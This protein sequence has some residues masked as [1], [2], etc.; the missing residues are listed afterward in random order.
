M[1][2]DIDI[3]KN[4]PD[5]KP[6]RIFLPLK[7]SKQLYRAQCVYQKSDPPKLSLLFKPGFLPVDDISLSQPCIISIDMG[8]PNVSLEAMIQKVAS[9]QILQMI[10]KKSISHEQMREFFR[11]D[12]T[13]KIISKSFH[14]ELFGNK[15]KAWSVEGSTVDISGSGILALFP[16]KTPA[17][18]Q[19][20]LEISIPSAEPETITVLAHQVRAVK[21]EDNRY[22]I[23]YHFDDISTEDRD[24]IIGCC[25][26]IQRK[27]L[28]LKVQV[29]DPI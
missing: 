27:L 25:L 14:T 13:T 7:D 22:E 4:I 15:N 3:L 8:G 26:V 5:G 2:A 21:L 18:R 28:Q 6:V 20:R 1:S 12:A 17:D 9:P 16:E 29:K 19:I 10:V 11:V 24:K 23:A